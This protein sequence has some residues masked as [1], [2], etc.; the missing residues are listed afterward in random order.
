MRKVKLQK[1]ALPF[2][3]KCRAGD[4]STS[5][6]YIQFIYWN[7]NSL[8][9]K[10]WTNIKKITKCKNIKT[11]LA[12]AVKCRTSDSSIWKLWRLLTTFHSTHIHPAPVHC[13]FFFKHILIR[14]NH[15]FLYR[16]FLTHDFLFIR[17]AFTQHWRNFL[18]FPSY[19]FMW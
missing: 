5:L 2:A 3:V 12:V 19:I 15:I 14:I 16:I 13:A 10:L 4:G 8:K 6:Y 9:H 1:T 17:P 11:A 7:I 18:L